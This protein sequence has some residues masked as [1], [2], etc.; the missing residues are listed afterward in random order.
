MRT[1][2][3]SARTRVVRS[4]AAA[5]GQHVSHSS[6]SKRLAY[7]SS[8]YAWFRSKPRTAYLLEPVDALIVMPATSCWLSNTAATNR[9]EGTQCIVASG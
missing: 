1:L 3:R 2:P 8:V 7:M 4:S 6:R 9:T 5:M